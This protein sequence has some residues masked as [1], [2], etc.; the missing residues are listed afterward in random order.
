MRLEPSTP[1]PLC[2]RPRLRLARARYCRNIWINEFYSMKRA[3][4]RQ[5]I[6]INT[7]TTALQDELWATVQ[8]AASTQPTPVVAL[9][10]F[11]HERRVELAGLHSG[12]LVE[13]HS[14]RGM[15]HDGTDSNLKQRS[16]SAMANDAEAGCGSLFCRSSYQCRCC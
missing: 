13:S 2:C 8:Q 1:G 11:G 12:S 16:C 6:K 9:A 10:T 5:L 4:K 15:G 14:D 7:V 3:M